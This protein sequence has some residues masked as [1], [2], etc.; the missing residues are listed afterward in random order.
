MKKDEANSRML[1]Q[2]AEMQLKKRL[3]ESALPASENDL[4]KL[5]HEFE[6]H[7]IELEMQNHELLLAQERTVQANDRY[8]E[9]YDFAPIGYFTLS[10][11]GKILKL[12]HLGAKMLKKE[13][14]ILINHSFLSFLSQDSINAFNLF[15]YRIFRSK[16]KEIEEITLESDEITSS[17]FIASGIISENDDGFYLTLSDVTELKRTQEE[18]KNNNELLNQSISEKDKFFSIVAHDLRGPFNGFLGLTQLLCEDLPTLDRDQI[19]Q[20]ATL[21]RNSAANVFNLIENLLD[22]SR[23]QR[24][25]TPFQAETINV[26][27]K[28]GPLT[29]SVKVMATKKQ[30][31]IELKIPANLN[32]FVDPNMFSSTIRNLLSNAVKFTPHNG[33]ITISAHAVDATTAEFSIRDTGIGMDNNGLEKLFNLDGLSNR[34]GTDAEPSTGLGLLLC[35]EFVEK[36]GGKIWVESVEK[37][38]STFYFTC[39]IRD[40]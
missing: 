16:N 23:M 40:F 27:E 24:N 25:L 33:I 37:V 1:R 26:L 2:K 7:Q 31:V 13:R 38:G 19:Q 35:K 34:P 17:S 14:S 20:M 12:N 22:W 4:L 5:I 21:M 32:V 6:V 9:L 15:M 10:K 30:T 18:L 3:Q 11:E 28:I 36:N 29:E 8:T 39:P